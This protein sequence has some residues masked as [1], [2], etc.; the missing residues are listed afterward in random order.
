MLWGFA[1]KLLWEYGARRSASSPSILLKIVLSVV[2]QVCQ[3]CPLRVYATQYQCQLLVEKGAGHLR[4]CAILATTEKQLSHLS[5][6]CTKWRL[7]PC[8]GGWS[9]THLFTHGDHEQIVPKKNSADLHHPEQIA[10]SRGILCGYVGKVYVGMSR[11][12]ESREKVCIHAFLCTWTQIR[13][14]I[15]RMIRSIKR[16]IG[17]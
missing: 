13:C 8:R 12:L 2:S 7:I 16:T 9:T 15:L 14:L 6:P 5:I 1:N 4:P 11:H 10:G 17:I 3:A